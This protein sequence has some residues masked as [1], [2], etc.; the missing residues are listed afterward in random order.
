[1]SDINDRF[2]QLAQR[3]TPR[4]GD[5]VLAAARR[6]VDEPGSS[7]APEDE[8]T[9]VAIDARPKSRPRRRFGSGIAAAGVAAMLFVGTLA[10]A[11]FLGGGGGSDS[12]E[13]AVRQ[14]AAAVSNEDPIAAADVLAP[15]EVRSL[16]QTVDRTAHRAQELELAKSAT[17]PLAGLDLSVDNLSLS[18]EPLADGYVKVVVN[19]GQISASTDNAKFGPLLQESLSQQGNPD[20]GGRPGSADLATL[21]K[22]SDLPTFV[23]AVQRDGHWYVSAAYTTLEYIREVNHLP[24]ADFGS[25][26]RAAATLGAGSPDA[27]VTEGMQAFAE[28]DW[29]KLIELAPPN[30]I[31]T[32]DYRAALAQL[33]EDKTRGFTIDKLET[34]ST[35]NGDTAKVTI[36][37]AGSTDSGRW[38]LDGG[39]LKPPDDSYAP[40]A[41][42]PSLRGNWCAAPPFGY[43][44]NYGE[45][46]NEAA[47]QQVTVVRENGRWFIS[48]MGSVLDL[49][50]QYVN[51]L[52]QR[53]LATLLH[54]EGRLPSDGELTLGTPKTIGEAGRGAY[55][56]SF[57]GHR[58]QRL[59][60]SFSVPPGW[61]GPISFPYVFTPDGK[62]MARSFGLTTG[63]ALELP[64]DGVYKFALAPYFDAQTFTIWN[65]ADAPESAKHP[66]GVND[67]GECTVAPDGSET[68]TSSAPAPGSRSS[69]SSS[70]S[71]SSVS[72][73]VEVPGQRP[74]TATTFPGG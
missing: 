61:E 44:L 69:S 34:A 17:A 56:Y 53:E 70:S 63:E 16:D 71:S 23:V 5:A 73:S 21:A 2:E 66:V 11:A 39:C 32:Y 46:P 1:M 48:P 58:G 8:V 31:P 40:F 25:G 28:R 33:G 65:E 62:R 42:A 64:A 22:S 24:P 60:G 59:L 30:E 15:E 50:D 38:S 45:R 27:A 37:A 3:G 47:T 19:G 10:F 18:S 13:G 14:L 12:P 41:V 57:N 52:T 72:G 74:T 55:V 36:H 9:V 6:D 43:L 26:V 35:V 49:V 20:G 51:R 67:F 68:C 54:V 4:G 7:R 29:Q